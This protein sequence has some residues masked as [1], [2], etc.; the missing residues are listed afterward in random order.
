MIAYICVWSG[1]QA[2]CTYPP[3]NADS[4]SCYSYS[5]MYSSADFDC[6][7]SFTADCTATI[8]RTCHLCEDHNSISEDHELHTWKHVLVPLMLT[9]LGIQFFS[10][11]YQ[12]FY[13]SAL[14]WLQQTKLENAFLHKGS[15][16]TEGEC[17]FK[18]T[19]PRPSRS[20]T[21]V[22]LRSKLMSNG[23][24]ILINNMTQ[25]SLQVIANLDSTVDLRNYALF[26]TTPFTWGSE[27]VGYRPH[28]KP[29]TSRNLHT[30]NSLTLGTCME[31]SGAAISATLGVYS[32]GSWKV[33]LAETMVAIL[34]METG[35]HFLWSSDDPF[36][37]SAT[38]SPIKYH[39]TI[40]RYTPGYIL[41]VSV[42]SI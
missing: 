16:T 33:R 22:E 11:T 3:C 31:M 18:L 7:V 27:L 17:C 40:G 24:P 41:Q 13:M 21:F 6:T 37:R 14:G 8:A 32:H 25:H 9:A 12:S 39:T 28:P 10:L 20:M 1:H 19:N 42:H 36:G 30:A 5:E 38:G 4:S 34:G 23:A 15:R 29:L 35:R 2:Y 26:E